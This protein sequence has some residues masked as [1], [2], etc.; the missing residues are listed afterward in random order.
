MLVTGGY[1]TKPLSE[2]HANSFSKC[3]SANPR[4]TNVTTSEIRKGSGKWS[5]FYQPANEERLNSLLQK[6]AQTRK[7]RATDQKDNYQKVWIG[8]A[9]QITNL[10]T[11][12]QY[13]TSE[14]GCSCPDYENRGKALGISCK[15]QVLCGYGKGRK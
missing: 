2:T 3:L 8:Y 11:G 13:E 12:K 14:Y 10:N 1:R 5:V 4:F 7:L 15:H 6:A 9:Y